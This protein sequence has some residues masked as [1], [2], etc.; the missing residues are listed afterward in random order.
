M[1]PNTSTP[2][3]TL[4]PPILISQAP[5]DLR[6]WGP[7]QFPTLQ[8]LPNGQIQLAFH[9]GDDAAS[10]YGLPPH[11][12]LSDDQG[13][14][15]NPIQPDAPKTTTPFGPPGL[16]RIH[17]LPNGDLLREV[18]L[19]SQKIQDVQHLLPDPIGA[20]TGGYGESVTL[21]HDHQVPPQL[22]GFRFARLLQDADQWIEEAAAVHVP[23][24]VRSATDGV[25]TFP[26]MHRTT[27]A[28]DSS[29][30]A[31]SHTLRIVDDKIPQYLDIRFVRSTDCGHT[32]HF[33][34]DIPYQ[35][36]KQADPLWHKREGFTEPDITFLPDGSILCLIRSSDGSGIAP[37]YSSRST[38]LGQTW[39]TPEVFDTLGV[40][41]EIITLESGI[42]LATYGRPGLY[43]RA[44]AD[45][46][47]QHWSPKQTIVPP[48]K[49]EKNTC[50]YSALL[51][52]DSCTALIAYSHF[53][54]P[55]DQRRP[56]KSILVRRVH[57]H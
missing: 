9:V 35:P 57:I 16:P 42:T 30:W 32:F 56:R 45:P 6:Q 48:G 50:S 26:W 3:I 12:A 13:Q 38:D 52:I 34:S 1:M 8:H 21:Y 44:A 24:A 33:L 37:L 25:F 5:P 47:A 49:I 22:A 27:L 40:W 18:V 10:A 28:P 2:N 54:V 7:W 19:R 15:W 53:H 14:T 39:S 31:V 11:A 29:L 17:T 23:G 36:D 55:D 20:W 4:D 46:A 43:L 51:P 41:P